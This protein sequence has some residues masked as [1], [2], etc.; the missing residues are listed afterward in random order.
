MNEKKCF[1]EIDSAESSRRSLALVEA[2]YLM[3]AF[4]ISYLT[5]KHQF[6]SYQTVSLNLQVKQEPKKCA[7]FPQARSCSYIMMLFSCQLVA[8]YIRKWFEPRRNM[9]D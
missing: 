6:L 5:D 7:S 9:L 3:K 2:L 4:F 8:I 1:T